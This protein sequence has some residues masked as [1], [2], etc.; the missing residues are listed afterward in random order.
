MKRIL[1]LAL[2][3]TLLLLCGSANAASLDDALASVQHDWAH[4]YY[5]APKDQKEAA[6]NKLMGESDAMLQAYPD[7]AEAL[8]WHAIVLSS[9]AKFSGGLN[10]LHEVKQ[11]REDLEKA[12]QLDPRAL[13]G[14]IYTSLGS[15]YANVPGWPLA[16]GDKKK[17]EA[18]LQQALAINPDGID[19]NFFYGQLLADRGD[20]AGAREYYEKALAAP[21]RPGRQ[22]ADAG[23]R[24]EIQIA[25]SK[26]GGSDH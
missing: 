20:K 22:D 5:A 24:Q 11:A 13:N 6:F 21:A 3:G 17:A 7:R 15:L 8:T 14:S 9:A 23:R 4:A 19:P 2:P 16:Y 1:L 18:Y 25:L 12:M 26:L 10:A